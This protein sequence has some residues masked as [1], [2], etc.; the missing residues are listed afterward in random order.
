MGKRK[1]RLPTG[2]DILT[3]EKEDDEQLPL[4]KVLHVRIVV[5]HRAS[6]QLCA[7]S[8]YQA[9]TIRQ[10][11]QTI[12]SQVPVTAEKTLFGK[13]VAKVVLLLQETGQRNMKR[14]RFTTI[15]T[16]DNAFYANWYERNVLK[17]PRTDLQS[18]RIEVHML[19]DVN[20]DIAEEH[21]RWYTAAKEAGNG[22]VAVASLRTP[23][24]LISRP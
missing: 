21:A 7:I 8:T 13:P 5:E 10:F 20:E 17:S 18:L 16:T 6:T 24:R 3:E 15:D 9:T 1:R 12:H 19:V 14:R 4:Q 23:Y 2:T 22:G 11:L